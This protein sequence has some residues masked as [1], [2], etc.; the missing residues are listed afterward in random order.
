MNF[1]ANI[2]I[3]WP[4]EAEKAER[5]RIIDAELAG[6]L[7][8]PGAAR[9]GELVR[10]PTGQQGFAVL[11]RRWVVERTFAWIVRCRRLRCD[12]ERLPAHAEAM[13]K[14]AMI[15]LMTRRLAPAPGRHPWQSARAA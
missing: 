12:Y 7:R 3:V 5:E 15:G 6:R 8:P 2:E 11:P 1:L 13:V 4:P 14:W 10:K 9:D